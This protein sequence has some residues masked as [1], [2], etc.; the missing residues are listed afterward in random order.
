MAVIDKLLTFGTDESVAHAAGT[1]NFT[2]IIDLETARDVGNGQPLYLVLLCTGGTS[3][4]IT[5]GSAGTIAFQ[6]V[7]DST[8]TIATDGTQSIH[9]KTKAYV[10]DDSAL[11]EIDQGKVIFVGAIPVDGQEPYERYL[12]LQYV[13]AT[14]TTTEGTVTA[15]LSIDP[16]TVW[17]SYPD[18]AVSW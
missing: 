12:A 3:G 5:G 10:T 11:N 18:A 17:K 4:I 8:T 16:P 9:L 13:V 2:N 14:T 1:V 7:S 6:L 15:Y